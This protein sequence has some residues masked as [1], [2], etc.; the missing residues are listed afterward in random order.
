M[1]ERIEELVERLKKDLADF[2]GLTANR[3][4]LLDEI[5]AAASG[6]TSASQEVTR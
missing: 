3:L 5:K 1:K 6:E 4:Y 2:G